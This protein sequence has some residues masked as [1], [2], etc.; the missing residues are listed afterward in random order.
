MRQLKYRDAQRV[1]HASLFAFVLVSGCSN[2][3]GLA[4]DPTCQPAGANFPVCPGETEDDRSFVDPTVEV[5]NA[6]EVSLARKVYVGP[7]ARLLAEGSAGIEIGE[8]SNLQDNVTVQARASRDAQGT[9]AVTALGLGE[10]DGVEVSERVILAHGAT[11]KGPAKIGVG[12]GD[13]PSDPDLDQEVFLSFGTEVDGAILERNTGVSALGRVGPGV[14]LRSGFIVLPGKNVT[15]QAEADDLA[16]GKVR[17]ITEAD[18]AFNEAVIEVNTAFAREYP[19]LYDEDPS[20]VLGISPDPGGT[21]F[22]HERNLPELAGVATRA[23]DF[24]N[25]IIGNVTMANT[26]EELEGLMG[27]RVAIRADEGEPF[28]VGTI[29]GMGSDVI[30]HALEETPIQIGNDVT[31]GNR[32]IIHGGGRRPLEG[33]ASDEPTIIEDGVVLR[34]QAVVFRS[35]I[36][37]GAT[38]GTKSAIVSTDIAP[39]TTVPDR[40]IYVNNAL[41]GPVEW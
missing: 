6:E 15:T 32:V 29:T 3:E 5:I 35:L 26:L 17:A 39:G 34:D 13:I 2:D 16:L 10:N 31:Y 19:R 37:S 1:S 38:I 40:T 25:R 9:A 30:F 4:V 11:V 24:R 33:G 23:P 12:G 28:T 8:E 21:S 27:D 7:F 22:N 20:D 18:V 14:T 41:F 36:G